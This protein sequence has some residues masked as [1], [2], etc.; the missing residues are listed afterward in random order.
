M[1]IYIIVLVISFIFDGLISN[2][3]PYQINQINFLKPMFTIS[4]LILIY[5]YFNKNDI[6][7][8]KVG[9]ICGLF[10]DIVYTNTFPLNTLLFFILS[11]FI[12]M[13]NNILSNNFI[14]I[15]IMTIFTITVFEFLNYSILNIINYAHI[16]IYEMFYKVANSLL[17]NVIYVLLGNFILNNISKKYKIKRID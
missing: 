6:K 4:S 10:Y 13:I 3:L 11:I 9:T 15:I 14:N 12:K 5:P 8:Y 16:T 2:F 1:K 17:L 7:F